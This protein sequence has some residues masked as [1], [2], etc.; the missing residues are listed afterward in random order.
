MPSAVDFLFVTNKS[1]PTVGDTILKNTAAR[2]TLVVFGK[3]VVSGIAV[4]ADTYQN[5]CCILF[6]YVCVYY[7]RQCVI[8]RTLGIL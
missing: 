5:I 1:S 8:R 6:H 3:F 4:A 7:F 2:K